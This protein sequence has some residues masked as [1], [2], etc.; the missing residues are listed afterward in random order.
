ML[1]D[2]ISLVR[3]TLRRDDELV[4]YKALVEERFR[5]WLA[6]QEQ[7]GGSFTPEQRTWLERMRDHVGASMSISTEDFDYT[8]FA[9][10]GG[11]GR[12][13]ELF[14]ERL[15]PLLEELSQVLAA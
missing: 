5:D 4:P 10:H 7:L 13:L 9:E 8:P 3:F 11:I 14:G 15:N 12:A 1:T 2:L 6:K